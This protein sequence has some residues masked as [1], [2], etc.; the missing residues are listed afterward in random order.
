MMKMHYFRIAQCILKTLQ[1]IAIIALKRNF[2]AWVEGP[3]GR[4]TGNARPGRRE[5]A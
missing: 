4:I 5:A 1:N 2:R 3:D